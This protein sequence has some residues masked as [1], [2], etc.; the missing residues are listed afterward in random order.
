MLI[1]S[2]GCTA[3]R[4]P[5]QPSTNVSKARARTSAESS[6]ASVKKQRDG[7][8][9]RW[10]LPVLTHSHR[11]NQVNH[12]H[13]GKYTRCSA[14]QSCTRRLRP[15][16]NATASAADD[17]LIHPRRDTHDPLARRTVTPCTVDQTRKQ[18]PGPPRRRL[19]S[20]LSSSLLL[21]P[22][23]YSRRARSEDSSTGE[24]L[25]RPPREA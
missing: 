10:F 22:A 4:L 17:A 7:E 8:R 12:S 16:A 1:S 6:M 19:S 5:T 23:L 21:H 14:Q 11:K 9:F 15:A 24:G 2:R 20:F 3:A 13:S 25:L 18:D